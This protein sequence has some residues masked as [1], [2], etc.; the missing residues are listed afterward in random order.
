MDVDARKTGEP[1]E[2]GGV[3]PLLRHQ[4]PARH[5]DAQQPRHPLL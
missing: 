4:R 1:V 3:R 5:G 2:S